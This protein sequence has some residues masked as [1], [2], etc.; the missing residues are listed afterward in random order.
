MKRMILI[1]LA[2]VFVFNLGAYALDNPLIASR[3]KISKESQDIKS[4]LLKSKDIVLLNSMWDSCI[5]A[6]TQ[7]DAYFYLVG[8]FNTIKKENLSEASI[9]YLATWLD[10]MKKTNDVN[11]KS[12][13]S[14]SEKIEAQTRARLLK[15]KE[16]FVNLNNQLMNETKKVAILKS[17]LLSKV[18]AKAKK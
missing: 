1:A 9:N 3:N 16:A 13:N 6:M 2:L 8:I 14:V 10:I 17:S 4:A 5:L 11:I 7:L 18:T 12:L 15:L